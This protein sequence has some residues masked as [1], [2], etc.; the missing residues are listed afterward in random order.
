MALMS[1]IV[2]LWLGIVGWS[3]SIFSY[4]K[5][6]TGQDLTWGTFIIQSKS[7]VVGKYILFLVNNIVARVFSC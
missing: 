3:K 2:Y 1:A 7:H 4:T 6:I 5:Y